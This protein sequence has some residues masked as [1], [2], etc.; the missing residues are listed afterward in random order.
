MCASLAHTRQQLE[1]RHARRAQLEAFAQFPDKHP[2]PAPQA[3][4][5]L[6]TL[7]CVLLV[8]RGIHAQAQG[9]RPPHHA[10]LA[11]LRTGAP[12]HAQIAQQGISV[13]PPAATS[14]WNALLAPT[15]RVLQHLAHP[16]LPAA[17]APT[18]VL[19][20]SMPAH[21]AGTALAPRL[22]A[23][24]A[25]LGTHAQMPMG[26]G[27]LYALQALTV[28]EARQRARVAQGPMFVLTQPQ[29]QPSHA[30]LASTRPKIAP[31]ALSALLASNAQVLPKLLVRLG[32]T[33]WQAKLPVLIVPRATIATPRTQHRW[34]CVPRALCLLQARKLAHPALQATSAQ[35][36]REPSP[37]QSAREAS[38]LLAA[39][40]RV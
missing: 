38:T 19:L 33:R 36:P 8:H 17:N 22:R 16:A 27:S 18:E 32:H 26:M 1:H 40:K 12:L 5:H 11:A 20:P 2:K 7:S 25:L 15:P 3:P 9:W 6:P 37:R 14:S 39:V 31:T 34:E 30:E 10:L 35:T 29:R 24:C 28:L 21:L 13:H 4:T 23:Q